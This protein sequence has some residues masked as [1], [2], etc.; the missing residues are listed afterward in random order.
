M[1]NIERPRALVI[2]HLRPETKDAA[3]QALV[4]AGY[5]LDHRHP[6]DGDGLPHPDEGHAIALMHGS[7]ADVTKADAPG[8]AEEQRWIEAWW[9]SER[10][11]LGI[12]H[13]LQLA[14]QMLGGYVGPPDHEKAEFG[15]Y[16]LLSHDT[17]LVPDGLHVF[18]WHYYGAACPDGVRRVAGSDLY[19]NQI[20]DFGLN[21]FGLQCHAELS[22]ED[23][24][25]LRR[26]DP[27]GMTRQGAQ[28]PHTQEQ[29]AGKHYATMNA[30]M[31]GFV[32]GWLNRAASSRTGD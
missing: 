25:L 23:Q 17:D 20:L 28:D 29:L 24:A 12:C 5:D 31:R 21:R 8:I 6:I 10:P 2:H 22:L 1:S 13:G 19:P 9:Q 14:S 15:Y 27:D 32:G 7:L 18:Q 3:T 11:F 16:P 4:D 26:K 30:W